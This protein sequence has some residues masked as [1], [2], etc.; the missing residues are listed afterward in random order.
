MVKRNCEDKL[1]ELEKLWAE[2]IHEWVKIIE[3]LDEKSF[4]RVITSIHAKDSKILKELA[5]QSLNIRKLLLEV[6]L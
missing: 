1:K 2:E 5:V 6:L 3:E 4:R